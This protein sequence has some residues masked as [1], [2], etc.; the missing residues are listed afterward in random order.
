MVAFII[1]PYVTLIPYHWI[2]EKIR[3]AAVSDLI[4]GAIGLIVGLCIAA[5]ASALISPIRLLRDRTMASY[6]G[7]FRPG[8]YLYSRG[9]LAQRRLRPP[10]WLDGRSDWGWAPWRRS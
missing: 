2:R 7:S 10:V 6:S 4:A 5:L 8:L 1:T 3:H 9:G